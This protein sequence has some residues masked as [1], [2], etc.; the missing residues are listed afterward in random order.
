MSK[1]HSQQQQKPPICSA[2]EKPRSLHREPF[3]TTDTVSFRAKENCSSSLS[4]VGIPPSTQAVLPRQMVVP[5]SVSS[6]DGRAIVDTG[7]THT[8]LNEELCLRVNEKN[9]SLKPW[10]YGLLYLADGGA[11]QPLGWCEVGITLHNHTCTLTSLVLSSQTLAFPAVLRLDFL[12]FTGLQINVGDNSYWFKSEDTLKYFFLPEPVHQTEW[13]KRASV[14]FVSAVA[15]SGLPCVSV[16]SDQDLLI[17]AVRK[18]Q[19]DECGKVRFLGQLTDNKNVCTS[20]LGC[21]DVLNHNIFVT[22]DVPI[23]QKPYHVSPPKTEGHEG[24]H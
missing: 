15:P 10:T 20:S 4:P 9:S 5:L 13:S 24:A 1:F 21:T 17:A 2:A 11:R 3:Y 8:L 14:S 23:K 22:H 19:L 16:E 18:A 7:S 6:L 12:R